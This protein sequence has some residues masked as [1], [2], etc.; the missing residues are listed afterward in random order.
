MLVLADQLL[1]TKCHPSPSP[2]LATLLP[3]L[4]IPKE[5]FA[6]DTK[7]E[8]THLIVLSLI[9]RINLLVFA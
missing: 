9:L 8:G 4:L 5:Q 3:A 6:V 1:F 7:L 2:P